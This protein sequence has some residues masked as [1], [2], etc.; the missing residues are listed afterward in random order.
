MPLSPMSRSCWRSLLFVAGRRLWLWGEDGER[1]SPEALCLLQKRPTGGPSKL[2]RRRE[3]NLRVP[4]PSAVFARV[5][6]RICVHQCKSV[7]EGFFQPC[8]E[9]CPLNSTNL[10]RRLSAKGFNAPWPGCRLR[11]FA[12]PV[13]DA[14]SIRIGDAGGAPPVGRSFSKT[15]RSNPRRKSRTP[16]P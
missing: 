4:H 10:S 16:P 11:W 5:G 13:C 6:L 7:A 15:L 12:P 3:R 8:W 2:R 1:W 14:G 9:G